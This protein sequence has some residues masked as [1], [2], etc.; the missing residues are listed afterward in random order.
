M[1]LVQAQQTKRDNGGELVEQTMSSIQS[2][3]TGAS[4]GGN[5]IPSSSSG[6]SQPATQGYQFKIYLMEICHVKIWGRKKNNIGG[7]ETYYKAT[8]IKTIWY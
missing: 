6:S 3:L 8:V 5:P 7:L 2:V 1:G 4:Q